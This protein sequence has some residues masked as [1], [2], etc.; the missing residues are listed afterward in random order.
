MNNM[1]NSLFND[2]FGMMGHPSHNAI[3]HGNHRNRN[4][5]DDLQVLPFGFP[6]LP[7]FNMG[8]IFS[9]FVCKF[10]F[11]IYEIYNNKYGNF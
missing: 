1:M 9:N 5:Q 6:P 2:P 4:H 8:N 7:S 10:F 3:A 11:L